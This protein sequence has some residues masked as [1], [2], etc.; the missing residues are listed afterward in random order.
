MDK[1]NFAKTAW[2]W[3]FGC[4]DEWTPDSMTKFGVKVKIKSIQE[5]DELSL[6]VSSWIS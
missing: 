2:W 1:L 4:K 6:C 5:D 3:Q